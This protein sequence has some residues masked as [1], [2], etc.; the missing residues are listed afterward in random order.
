MGSRIAHTTLIATLF[1]ASPAAHP[2]GHADFIQQMDGGAYCW[3]CQATDPHQFDCKDALDIFG[4]PA[5][6]GSM[7]SGP[8]SDAC[9]NLG[10]AQACVCNVFMECAP[11]DGSYVDSDHDEL[12]NNQD[13]CPFYGPDT[14]ENGDGTL[15]CQPYTDDAN[16]DGIPD[17]ME[18]TDGDGTPD[19]QEDSDGDGISDMEDLTPYGP[20]NDGDGITN[21]SDPTPN[22]TDTSMCTPGT[23]AIPHWTSVSCESSGRGLWCALMSFN[24]GGTTILLEPKPA[25]L[26]S[27]SG[28]YISTSWRTYSLLQ[29]S[30]ATY[31]T[32]TIIK[33]VPYEP[34]VCRATGTLN[35]IIQ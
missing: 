11:D 18:D 10:Y 1:L 5:D 28:A 20:D 8:I 34:R 4:L 32:A 21:A 14:D 12:A 17:G 7:C 24:D 25:Y 13:P 30:S 6:E 35:G 9:E 2:A 3:D 15:D 29:G 27:L 31:A 26:T 33:D 16:G 22:G 19:S 23:H